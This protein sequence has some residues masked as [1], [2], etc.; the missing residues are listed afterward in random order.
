VRKGDPVIVHGRLRTETWQPEEGGTTTT[1][2]VDASL[3]G[4]DLTRGISHFIKQRIERPA[5]DTDDA[6]QEVPDPAGIDAADGIDA[7]VAA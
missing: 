2:Q 3:I 4:H 6:G 1:L 5:T 7:E